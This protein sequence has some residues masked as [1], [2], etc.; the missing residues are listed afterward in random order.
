M[1]VSGLNHVNIR[2]LDMPATAHFY[3]SILGL[4]YDGTELVNGRPRNW[5]YDANGHPIIHLRDLAPSGETTG[6]FD[7]VAL[8]CEDMPKV[9]ERLKAQNIDYAVIDT[10]VDGVIQM[11]LKD[12]NGIPLELNFTAPASQEL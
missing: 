6:A 9:V 11:F 1:T 12:P 4:R 7:H 8:N 2:T 3:T 5:L 10:V